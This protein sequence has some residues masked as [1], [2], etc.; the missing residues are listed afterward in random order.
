[1]KKRLQEFEKTRR[2][3]FGEIARVM[4]YL[5]RMPYTLGALRVVPVRGPTLGLSVAGPS[6]FGLGLRALR[7]F[8]VCGLGH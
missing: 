5:R 8:G 7:L 2:T 6:G 3:G 1:M 4:G